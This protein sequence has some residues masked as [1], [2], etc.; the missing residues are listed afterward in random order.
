MNFQSDIMATFENT[1]WKDICWLCKIMVKR[2]K[3]GT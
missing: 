3:V 1:I 2:A